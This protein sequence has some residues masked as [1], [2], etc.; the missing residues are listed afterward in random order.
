MSPKYLSDT[1]TKTTTT[2]D[3]GNK[4][5]QGLLTPNGL[6]EKAADVELDMFACGTA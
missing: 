6:N 1:H 3:R 2:K 5:V 4:S